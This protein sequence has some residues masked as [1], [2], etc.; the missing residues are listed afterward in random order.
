MEDRGTT[1]A[2]LISRLL[3][4]QESAFDAFVNEFYPRLYR[5]AFRR[6]GSDPDATQD[7]VQ[8]TF[9]KVI[10]KLDRYRGEAALFTWLCSFCRF[11][12]AAFWR[13][14][15]RI[16]PE[17]IDDA[18]EV[19]A[20]L[21]S[22]ARIDETPEGD[23]ERKELAHLVRLT[24]DALPI[25]YGNA[26]EWKYLHGWSVQQIAERLSL[27]PKAAESLLTR[28]REAFRDGFGELAGEWS[29]S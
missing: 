21:E 7:V 17:S 24:L 19:R 23:L 27:T 15:N 5:F 8:S 6:V 3:E 13:Q 22:L 16:A 20:A 28:A 1:D 12:I 14:R 26:L 11:E 18:S 2:I 10:P 9:E 25:R 4:G 29:R